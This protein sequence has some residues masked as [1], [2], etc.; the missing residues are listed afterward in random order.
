MKR[1]KLQAEDEI[2]CLYVALTRAK[3]S[4]FIIKNDESFKTFKSYFKDYEEKQIG[5]LENKPQ[6]EEKL[7]NLEQIEE[8]EKFQKVNLQEIKIKNHLSS[9]QIHFGL[10]LHE[11][12]QYFDFDEKNNFEFCKQ[13]IYKKYRFFLDDES[14]KDLFKRL[15]ML[16]EN[17][18]FNKLLTKKALLKEQIITYNGEQKQ[19][20][21]LALSDDEAIIIDYKTGLNLNEH[22]NQ[23]LLYKEA[24][25]KIL[26][27]TSTKAFLV[28]VLKD[29]VEMMEV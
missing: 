19:L 3:N 9:K 21:M 4:L 24:I 26:A 14:F 25:E 29:K 18:N 11:F 8:F 2:N 23:V 13:M 17:E 5:V 15:M 28:Y 22:K 1:K 10:A 12:L 7:K 16:L 27:K 6:E 20:D